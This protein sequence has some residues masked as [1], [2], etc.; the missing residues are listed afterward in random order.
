[1]LTRPAEA[2]VSSCARMPRLAQQRMTRP[3]TLADHGKVAW[4]LNLVSFQA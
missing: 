4:D 3:E 2:Q 1:M